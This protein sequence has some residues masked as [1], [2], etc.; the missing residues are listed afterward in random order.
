MIDN[1]ADDFSSIPTCLKALNRF[2]G[3]DQDKMPI[4]PK[5]GNNAQSNNPQT[6]S[7]FKTAMESVN[8]FP[9]VKGIGIQLGKTDLGVLCGID[10]D[11][12][13]DE[14]GN[15]EKKAQEIIDK[16]DSYTEKSPSKKGVHI[17][18][19]AEKKEN[20]CKNIQ[21]PFCKAFEMY[22]F[23]RYFTLTGD[24]LNDKDIEARQEQCDYIYN[25]YLEPKE[26]KQPQNVLNVSTGIK[27]DYN[28]LMI[29]L[30]NDK[31]LK[32]LYNGDRASKDESSNDCAF[33]SK[34]MY[35]CN[36]NVELAIDNF[37]KSP[38]A[39]QKDV[40]HKK[41]LEREDYLRRTAE[42]CICD[43]TACQANNEFL[44]SSKN[45]AVPTQLPKKLEVMSAVDLMNKE[46]QPLRWVVDNLF[47]QGLT[48]LASPPKYGKSWL[49]LAL[50]ICVS[51]GKDFLGYKTHIGGTFY[52]ALEDS[53]NRL[54]K[55]IKQV[56]GS[57]KPP[58]NF[59]LTIKADALSNGLVKML[60]DYMQSKPDTA[61]IIIDTLQKVR[62]CAKKNEGAYSADYR[63]VGELKT[64]A[65]KYG[66][67]LVLVHHLRKAKDDD[68]FNR[69]SGT[70]GIMGAA[71]TILALQKERREDEECILHITGRDVESEELVLKFNKATCQWQSIGNAE[72]QAEK[73]LLEQYNNEPIVMAIRKLLENQPQG[74]SGSAQEFLD[75]C[76]ERCNC[77]I[78][79]TAISV[80]KKLKKLGNL[81]FEIDN[82]VYIP[83][84]ENG[85]GGR[86]LHKF[87][88]KAT[89]N[90]SLDNTQKLILPD[91]LNV[92]D[93]I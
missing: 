43:T 24:R 8:K 31:K 4:N 47:V 86:R 15:I 51:Q 85:S 84:P 5:T 48:I 59:D 23:N 46:L 73:R 6:W 79:E 9:N 74:W 26:S 25:K 57:E 55:R 69:I 19:W 45:Q 27:S 29:G 36:N 13:I 58:K 78:C 10:I 65:D 11:D 80:A 83:P 53:Y 70:N 38:Y 76:A 18:F 81:M 67:C 16:I 35:W 82:I 22:D 56:L 40:T 52:L 72:K 12:C 41:K 44:A 3:Y 63:E 30:E 49:S 7:D 71:D 60:E 21:L 92:S 66:I 91:T 77:Y 93:T 54:Q 20:K 34:L 2:V 28:Y 64:F 1:N 88:P 32:L 61:L 89:Q 75:N 37:L 87:I 39:T 33:M 14:N 68:I 50:C 62:D 17:I 90:S 42:K